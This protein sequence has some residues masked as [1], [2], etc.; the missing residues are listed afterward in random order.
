MQGICQLLLVGT[1]M[2]G[3]GQT[4]CF[5]PKTYLCCISISAELDSQYLKKTSDQGL[6][7]LN[8]IYKIYY[9]F[10]SSEFFYFIL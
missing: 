4:G 1:E 6:I 9:N 10:Q 8:N 7:W 3:Q 5:C 2:K